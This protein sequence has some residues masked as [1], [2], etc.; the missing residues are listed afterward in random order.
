MSDPFYGNTPGT[1]YYGKQS[2]GMGPTDILGLGAGIAGGIGNALS[3]N[4]QSQLDQQK[5]LTALQLAEQIREYNRS[6]GL[7]EA[8]SA[9]GIQNDMNR[10]P[11]RDQLYYALAARMGLPQQSLS[12]NGM[13]S[14]PMPQANVNPAAMY[15]QKMAQYHPGAGGVKTDVSQQALNSLGYGGTGS[16]PLLSSSMPHPAGQK[17]ND[18]LTAY[19]KNF[20]SGGMTAPGGNPEIT[21]GTVPGVTNAGAGASSTAKKGIPTMQGMPTKF[22]GFA[23]GGVSF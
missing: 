10:A 23:P 22:K 15:N 19:L 5:Y 21:T 3:N 20:L 11:M 18:Y 8:N 16:G 1:Y 17:M 12:Y 13:G 4:Q 2:S 7:N 6:Q 9:I 14:T